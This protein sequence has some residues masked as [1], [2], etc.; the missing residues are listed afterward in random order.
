MLHE[1][2]GH[3]GMERTTALCREHFYW[4]TVYKD[5][6]R[7]VRNYPQ[8]QVAIG[9]YVGPKTKP[10]SI[11]ANGPLDLLCIDLTKI[12]HSRD[13]KENVL[14][15]SDA[16]SKFSQGFVTTN[17]NAL[18][19]AKIKVDKRVHMLAYGLYIS[20]RENIG[21]FIICYQ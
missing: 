19:M 7:Y 8:C 4:S 2:K 3:Q 18:T 9:P 21:V 6:A 20:K 11:I 16:F 5:V 15:L 14:I 13:S 17:Q 12:G 10:G 1:G